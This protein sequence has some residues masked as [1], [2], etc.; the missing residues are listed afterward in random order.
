MLASAIFI[1]MAVG[2]AVM[3]W[4]T[5][6]PL[7]HTLDETALWPGGMAPFVGAYI[8]LTRLWID[9]TRR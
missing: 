6:K 4:V 2:M 5:D 9:R 3:L 7:A 8:P 1:L